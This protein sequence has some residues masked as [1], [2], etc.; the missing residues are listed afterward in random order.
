MMSALLPA[1][2]AS[3]GARVNRRREI[4]V[5][6]NYIEKS[7]VMASR[8]MSAARGNIVGGHCA[9]FVEA[10]NRFRASFYAISRRAGVA[11]GDRFTTASCALALC[12]QARSGK[13]RIFNNAPA[14]RTCW[15]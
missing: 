4:N 13:L 9:T 10:L 14:M 5:A 1:K 2:C 8:E 6:A 11:A 3:T 12:A 7:G 15:E